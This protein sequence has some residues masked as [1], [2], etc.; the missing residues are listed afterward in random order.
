[1]LLDLALYFWCAAFG[2]ITFDQILSFTAFNFIFKSYHF[3]FF[4]SFLLIWVQSYQEKR[5]RERLGILKK[6]FLSP[7]WIA[8][9]FMTIYASITAPSS[10]LPNKSIGYCLRAWFDF[11]SQI[12]VF[13]LNPAF[14]VVQRF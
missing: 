5:L 13:S 8:L 11:L 1:M 3:L 10:L 4:A 9:L 2:L 6:I 12:L 7:P 14:S